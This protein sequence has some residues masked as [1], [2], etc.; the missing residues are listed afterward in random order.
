[1]IR[2]DNAQSRHHMTQPSVTSRPASSVDLGPP[3]SGTG[4]LLV[5]TTGAPDA[6]A[7][8]IAARLF[9]QRTRATVQVVTVV[10]P[11][12]LGYTMGVIPLTRE[13]DADQR[14]VQLLAAKEQ[15][16][17]LAD[18]GTAWPVSAEFGEPA[19]V[20]AELARTRNA[21]LIVL[22]HGKHSTAERLLGGERVLQALQLGD[23]PIFAAAPELAAL[24]TRVIIATD[25]SD[26]S[27]YAAQFALSFVAPDAKIY[28]VN[29]MPDV[30]AGGGGWEHD[31]A[32]SYRRGLA[33]AFNT[34]KNALH[35]DE[36][37]IEPVTLT[38]NAAD[39]IIRFAGEQNA[40][41]VVCATHGHG[42]LRRLILGSV[43]TKLVRKLPCSVLCVPGSARTRAA[44]RT[45]ARAGGTTRSYSANEWAG[46]LQE[47]SKRNADRFCSIEVDQMDFGAQVEGSSVPFVGASYDPHDNSVSL[48]F[49]ER[50]EDGGHLTHTIANVTKLDVQVNT[51]GADQALR[52]AN[53]TGQT[54]LTLASSPRFADDRDNY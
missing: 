4:P 47:F 38:G 30:N 13:I 51:N 22:G 39:E 46:A 43:A 20:I 49:G 15:I 9:A 21:R 17:R 54:F 36:L 32:D 11:I 26:L 50:Q 18:S 42:F 10:A 48:M 35:R 24:P 25:F 41:L 28:L 19:Q 1:M 33:D 40:D 2:S 53:A 8:V 3:D 7:A 14:E 23:T 27:A 34:A 5:A 16:T 12:S 37:T 45:T 29:V 44:M 31:W 6:D 52:V